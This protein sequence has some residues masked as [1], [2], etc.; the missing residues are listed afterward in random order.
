MKTEKKSRA[1]AEG[2]FGRTKGHVLLWVG[3]LT[4]PLAFLT[5]LEINYAL[6]T[7]LCQSAHKISMHLVTL[8]FL[9]ISAAGGFIALRNWREV[10]S[11]WP[12]EDGSVTERSRFM[13]VVGLLISAIIVLALIWQWIPQFIFDPCQR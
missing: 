12:G 3:V 13:A 2:E 9:L 7:R 8:L 5:H 11:K 4:A 6:V 10:G 1:K